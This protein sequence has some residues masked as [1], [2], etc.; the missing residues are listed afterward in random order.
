MNSA[1]L[2]SL[3][4][5]TAAVLAVILLYSAWG[6]IRTPEATLEAFDAFRLPRWTRRRWLARMLPVG[7]AGLG[8]ALLLA[9]GWW[10]TGAVAVSVA[11]F[12]AF[13]WL[14]AA[15]VGRREEASCNC[16][17]KAASRMTVHTVR[18]NQ[19]L[20]GAALLALVCSLGGPGALPWS[21][22]WAAALAVVVLAALVWAGTRAATLDA[23]ASARDRV[24]VVRHGGELG[25]RTADGSLFPLARTARQGA[26]LLLFVQAA[27]EESLRAL[28]S[29]LR[30]QAADPEARLVRF[31]V[32][33]SELSRNV[34][35]SLEGQ[36][37]LFDSART[38]TRLIGLERYPAMVLVG[39]D[40]RFA[41]EPVVGAKDIEALLGDLDQVWP[42]SAS[43]T[44]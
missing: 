3:S 5:G 11:L 25:L 27:H 31:V 26:V 15:A 9:P 22:G 34:P 24:D 1:A 19:M 42:R 32:N 43:S 33:E 7:E 4:S 13:W 2:S 35:P 6:K 12:G 36:E 23:A 38:S 10:F 17:G 30:W 21:P 41:I 44:A 20:T 8:L 37:V 39:A 40:A 14:V 16:F 29:A 18:R 28:E